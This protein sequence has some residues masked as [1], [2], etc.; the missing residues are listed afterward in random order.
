[1]KDYQATSDGPQTKS[2]PGDHPV[3]TAPG[4]EFVDSRQLSGFRL[5]AL[6]VFDIL[7]VALLT[8]QA[9]KAE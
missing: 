1:M 9:L 4:S 3:A 7:R 5:S 6:F 2:E 8:Q